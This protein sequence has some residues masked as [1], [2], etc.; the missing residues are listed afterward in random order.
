MNSYIK[1]FTA[2]C[3][4]IFFAIKQCEF[5]GLVAGGGVGRGL[6]VVAI[7]APVVVAVAVIVVVEV[8]D[9]FLGTLWNMFSS[10]GVDSGGLTNPL[11]TSSAKKMKC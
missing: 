4:P 8:E 2:R 9:N 6:L 5:D 11:L 10:V 1:T 7:A 3:Q